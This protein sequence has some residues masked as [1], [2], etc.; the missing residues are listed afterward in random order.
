MMLPSAQDSRS[1]SSQDVGCSNSLSTAYA[2]ASPK[3]VPI[4]TPGIKS[5]HGDGPILQNRI[6][7]FTCGSA[8]AKVIRAELKK[9]NAQSRCRHVAT[10]QRRP[11]VSVFRTARRPTPAN[12]NGRGEVGYVNIREN[13][14]IARSTRNADTLLAL[15]RSAGTV[16]LAEKT[17]LDL[18]VNCV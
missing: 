12:R 14:I 6:C 4:A 17:V 16:I 8:V 11:P 2:I 13:Q 3:T 18:S 9:A 1:C 5:L 15:G 10:G 7:V